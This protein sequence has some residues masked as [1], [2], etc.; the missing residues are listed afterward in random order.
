MLCIP[1]QKNDF[2]YIKSPIG[3]R[4]GSCLTEKKIQ[5]FNKMYINCFLHYISYSMMK[6]SMYIPTTIN[7]INTEGKIN[8][9]MKY[10]WLMEL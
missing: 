9:R 8:K 4:L 3:L 7:N 1:S 5:L 6:T 10:L 2:K